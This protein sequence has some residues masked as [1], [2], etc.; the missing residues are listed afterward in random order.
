[1]KINFKNEIEK[2]KVIKNKMFKGYSRY[3]LASVKQIEF[4]KAMPDAVD[5]IFKVLNGKAELRSPAENSLKVF[6]LINRIKSK[7]L[8]RN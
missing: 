1:V 2:Y 8:C 4:G 3:D 7:E 6:E 5:N